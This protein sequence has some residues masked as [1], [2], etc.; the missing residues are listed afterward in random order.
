MKI[1]KKRKLAS[2]GNKSIMYYKTGVLP[3]KGKE[4]WLCL[5]SN[6][7]EPVYSGNSNLDV[8]AAYIKPGYKLIFSQVRESR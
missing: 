4:F 8:I 7:N 6:R 2:E 5:L 3:R 1:T